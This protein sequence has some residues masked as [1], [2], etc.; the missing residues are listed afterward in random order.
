MTPAEKQ[1]VRSNIAMND[2]SDRS[3]WA[4]TVERGQVFASARHRDHGLLM[5][6]LE[7][8]VSRPDRRDR[9]AHKVAA[10]CAGTFF[11]RPRLVLIGR[12]EGVPV[13]RYR[14]GR[15]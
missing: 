14:E 10:R 11:V 3:Q 6:D 4:V 5:L 13:F 7:V 2:A 8:G 15:V 1:R 9:R 12:R